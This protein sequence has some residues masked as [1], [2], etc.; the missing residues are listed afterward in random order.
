MVIAKTEYRIVLVTVHT[1][2]LTV[3]VH[4]GN[5]VVTEHTGNFV[6]TV[7]TRRYLLQYIQVTYTLYQ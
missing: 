1:G 5:F 6:V 4:T 3:T 7:H 2:N